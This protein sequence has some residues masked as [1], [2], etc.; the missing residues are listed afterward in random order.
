MTK[1][2]PLLIAESFDTAT[3]TIR[4]TQA[5]RLTLLQEQNVGRNVGRDLLQPRKKGSFNT[6]CPVWTPYR[7][8]SEV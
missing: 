3:A 8:A 5:R 4:V 6:G 7:F 1:N 2:S